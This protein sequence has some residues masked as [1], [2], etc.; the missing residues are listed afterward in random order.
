MC[1]TKTQHLRKILP[2]GW[3]TQRVPSILWES[4]EKVGICTAT[5]NVYNQSLLF[6]SRR[7][8]CWRR[9]ME[10][11]IAKRVGNRYIPCHVRKY[12]AIKDPDIGAVVRHPRPSMPCKRVIGIV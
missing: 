2:T 6:E 9:D 4:E 7:C 10:S 3:L 5:V 12:V 8:Q 1:H 11:G